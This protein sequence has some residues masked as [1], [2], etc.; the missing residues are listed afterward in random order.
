VSGAFGSTESSL[1][2][3]RPFFRALSSSLELLATSEEVVSSSSLGIRLLIAPLPFDPLRVHSRKPR[4]PSGRRYQRRSCSALVV[5]H[6]LGGFLRA[7]AAGLLHPAASSGVRRVSFLC[8]PGRR[9]AS[10]KTSVFPASRI[11]PFEEFPS[12]AAVPHHCGLCPPAVTVLPG[13]A[14]GLR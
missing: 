9:E 5:S 10:C 12:S 8:L 4:L 7:G 14:P 3:L 13:L 6:H 2:V 11:V 1:L